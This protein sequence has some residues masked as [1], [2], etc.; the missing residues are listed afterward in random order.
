M[1]DKVFITREIPSVATEL[2]KENNIEVRELN[3]KQIHDL[4]PNLAPVFY[5]GQ[6]FVGSRHTTNPLA[7]RRKIFESFNTR[8]RPHCYR[9]GS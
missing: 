2:L 1:K 3:K 7:I 4:E 6:L 9:P 8:F 5:A